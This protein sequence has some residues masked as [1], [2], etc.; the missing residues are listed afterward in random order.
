[1][2]KLTIKK[3][4]MFTFALPLFMSSLALPALAMPDAQNSTDSTKG[5]IE[6]EFP[7]CD[8]QL[9]FLKGKVHDVF[10]FTISD[11][12]NFTFIREQNYNLTGE[13]N[14]VSYVANGGE[15]S[16]NTG[17]FMMGQS[18]TEF[19]TMAHFYLISKGANTPNRYMKIEQH[20]TIN[21]NGDVT[22]F[23]YSFREEC[24]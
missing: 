21:R 11:D 13:L 12:G 16:S 1:M 14:G 22:A 17:K 9:L 20:V 23:H 8:N 7:T 24:Q 6:T 2:K 5:V 18:T 3:L 4:A 15:N 10:H 19:T